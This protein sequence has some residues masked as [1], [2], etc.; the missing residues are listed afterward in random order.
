LF[1]GGAI[2]L[3]IAS[4]MSGIPVQP[5]IA[6]TGEVSLKGKI[7]KIGGL[8]AKVM[9]AKQAGITKLFIPEENKGDYSEI[10]DE[11]KEG[12]EVKF[13]KECREILN[14]VL[15]ELKIS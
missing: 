10:P 13:V 1:V 8:K 3:A 4:L 12:I 14:E 5:K 9:A 11:I 2:S 15:P 7:T 6:M